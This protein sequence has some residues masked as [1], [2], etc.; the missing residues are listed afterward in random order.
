MYYNLTQE[1]IDKFGET[2]YDDWFDWCVDNSGPTHDTDDTVD[3][4]ATYDEVGCALHKPGDV[5]CNGADFKAKET[6][7]EEELY[8]EF[9]CD[10]E[11]GYYACYCEYN[12]PA[13][14]WDC[15]KFWTSTGDICSGI[16]EGDDICTV[17]GIWSEGDDGTGIVTYDC[18]CWDFIDNPEDICGA[19][20]VG[21]CAEGACPVIEGNVLKCF[22]VENNDG[23]L[24]C[25]CVP[26]LGAADTPWYSPCIGFHSQSNCEK[27]K[28]SAWDFAD[29]TLK[30]HACQWDGVLC[31]CPG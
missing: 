6:F 22:T 31:S 3:W 9:A 29:S 19:Q 25:A 28:C 17:K 10:N 11:R 14:D 21:S 24:E 27:G 30:T 2:D 16:C 26:N 5:N 15:G 18:N 7:C 8:G 1:F 23:G 13:I 4:R 20:D 12:T